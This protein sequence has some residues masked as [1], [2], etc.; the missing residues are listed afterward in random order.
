ML[1][2]MTQRRKANK[3]KEF[4][5]KNLKSMATIVA[6]VFVALGMLLGLL[7]PALPTASADMGVYGPTNDTGKTATD[8]HLTFDKK[9]ELNNVTATIPFQTK[10]ISKNKKTLHL[11]NGQVAKDEMAGITI[12]F[13]GTAGVITRTRWTTTGAAP[14]GD[15]KRV[16]SA[17]AMVS[18]ALTVAKNGQ[19]RQRLQDLGTLRDLDNVLDRDI[20]TALPEL[21]V[22]AREARDPAADI[23]AGAAALLGE[24]VRDGQPVAAKGQ[25]GVSGPVK[26]PAKVQPATPAGPAAP[27]PTPPPPAPPANRSTTPARPLPGGGPTGEDLVGPGAATG[28]PAPTTPGT[29]AKPVEPGVPSPLRDRASFPGETVAGHSASGNDVVRLVMERVLGRITIRGTD[30]K[31]V[32]DGGGVLARYR[33]RNAEGSESSVIIKVWRGTDQVDRVLAPG[34]SIDVVG[35]AIWVR[36][37]TQSDQATVFYEAIP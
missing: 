5:V 11:T 37:V 15:D 29:P 6:P 35:D 30:W 36:G 16:Q 27:A 1:E 33:I 8:L 10:N 26:E 22:L 3:G 20:P 9:F 17:D 32:Y 13:N 23:I 4:T 14:W 31:W 25:P 28:R 2:T 24:V 34:D 18:Q 19:L 7:P 21:A 12:E